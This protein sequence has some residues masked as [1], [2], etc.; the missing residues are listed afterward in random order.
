MSR[1]LGLKTVAAFSVR[2]LNSPT[3]T[4]GGETVRVP[5][6]YYAKYAGFYRWEV[7][8]RFDGERRA[9]K[10]TG[11]RFWRRRAAEEM[12]RCLQ[13]AFED[14]DFAD[15]VA[16]REEGRAASDRLDQTAFRRIDSGQPDDM[17]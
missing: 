12:A 14:G 10:V 2:L 9:W 11:V 8:C 3:L 4:P 16:L 15:R 17:V 1:V 6:R 5:R 7:W 13:F